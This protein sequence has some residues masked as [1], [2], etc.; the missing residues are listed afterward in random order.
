MTSQRGV[1]SADWRASG[2]DTDAIEGELRRLMEAVNPPQRAVDARVPPRASVLT[3]LVHA[4]SA[5]SADRARELVGALKDHH[6][7][8]TVVIQQ[9][10]DPGAPGLDADVNV[11]CHVRPAGE[12]LICFEEVSLRVHGSTARHLAQLVSGLIVSDLPV[13]L[14][15]PSDQPAHAEAL[16]ETC[17]R[18]IVDSAAFSKPEAEL[19]FIAQNAGR[20][21]EIYDL[22]WRRLAGWRH[23]IAQFFDPPDVR[24]F[25]SRIE[26]VEI[27]YVRDART[28]RGTAEPLLL[29]A[30]LSAREGW[31]LVDRT[32]GSDLKFEFAGP[33]GAIQVVLKG[34]TQQHLEAGTPL[35]LEI[36]A[37]GAHFRIVWSETVACAAT[38]S[39]VP[40]VREIGHVTPLERPSAAELLGRAVELGPR[41]QG[42]PSVLRQTAALLA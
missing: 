31:R 23:L 21:P 9:S 30:W 29:A 37:A 8:R 19:A 4:A 14:W 20:L 34:K 5:E 12:G 41:D 26:Q 42:Y 40:G 6:P 32:L 22:N 13:V 2:T 28:E 16:L 36:A 38:Q 35:R 39:E 33:A 27:E 10:H 3:L 17:D 25:Q 15:W 11:H 18:L 1:A 7:S 24:S